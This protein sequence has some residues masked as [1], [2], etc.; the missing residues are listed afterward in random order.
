MYLTSEQ[1]K[2][3][4]EYNDS[5][6]ELVK[7]NEQMQIEMAKA[8]NELEANLEKFKTELPKVISEALA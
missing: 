1:R 5:L 8:Y 7:Q 3:F 4:K 6:Q 2:A